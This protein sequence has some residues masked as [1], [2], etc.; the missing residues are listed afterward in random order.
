MVRPRGAALHVL[1][2]P[3]VDCRRLRSMRPG[4][5][6]SMSASSARYSCEIPA[7]LRADRRTPPER[8]HNSPLYEC[9][10]DTLPE[11]PRRPTVPMA[12][13]SSLYTAS[14]AA[15]P[16]RRAHSSCAS[17]SL[18]SIAIRDTLTM[19]NAWPNRSRMS[20]RWEKAA[21]SRL[22][23]DLGGRFGGA[24]GAGGGST[25]LSFDAPNPSAGPALTIYAFCPRAKS[26]RL[27]SCWR[28]CALRYA[29]RSSP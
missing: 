21:V 3:I 19:A 18:A 27:G 13:P 24:S 23:P 29:S 22:A 17:F 16:C 4:Y 5:V 28:R 6:R 9:A 2:L 8:P 12:R 20:L 15:I 10:H 7:C 1:R 26:Q 14:N 11:A 25:S